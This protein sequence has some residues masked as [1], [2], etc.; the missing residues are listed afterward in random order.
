MAQATWQHQNGGAGAAEIICNQ[1]LAREPRHVHA[2]NLLGLIQQEAGR[3]RAAAK[4]LEQAVASDHHNAACH[5]N[6]ASSYQALDRR[7][8]ATAHFIKAITFGAHYN[9]TEKLILQSPVVAACVSRVDAQGSWPA[10]CEDML[11]QSTLRALANDIFL[12]CAL[13]TVPIRGVA[14]ECFLTFVRAALLDLAYAHFLAT[15]PVDNDLVTLFTAVAQ[16]CFINEYVFAQSRRETEQAD[17]LR[18][19]LLLKSAAGDEIVPLLLASVAAYFPLH[20]L[21]PA[22]ELAARRW[23]QIP[24]ELVRQALREPLQEADDGKAI[25]GSYNRRR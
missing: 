4:T 9:N 8:E 22:D 21:P 25:S 12:R 10:S 24:S 3:H 18:T 6:L 23:P 5:Y 20:S 16:Q 13:T 2:L 19:L 15:A 11:S 17:A 1:V 7:D 14:L